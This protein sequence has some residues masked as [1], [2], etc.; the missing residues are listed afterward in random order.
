MYELAAALKRRKGSIVDWDD[1][2]RGVT[3]DWN[4]G[5]HFNVRFTHMWDGFPSYL[6]SIQTR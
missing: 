1:R 6:M 4:H 3:G 2:C 5:A